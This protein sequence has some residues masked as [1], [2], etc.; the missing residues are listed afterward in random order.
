M[1][2]DTFDTDKQ[3]FIV[4]EV[5]NNH[6]GDFDVAKRLVHKAAECNVDAVKFQTFRTEHFVSRS[7]AARFKQLKS[8]ELEFSQFEQLSRLAHALGLLFIST[9]LDLTSASFLK[10]IVDCYKVASGDNNFFPLIRQIALTGKP[11]IISTGL[12]DYGQ[13]AQVVE[14]VKQQWTENDITGQLAI[15]H[16]VSSYPAPPDQANLRSTQFLAEKLD[17]VVGYS[18]HTIGIEASLLAIALGA[19]IIEK[20]FTLDKAYSDFRDHQLSADP[21]E[22]KELVRQIRQAE[23]MLGERHKIV[24]P[25]EE[26]IVGALRR[27][28]VA[29]KDMAQGHCITESDLTWLRSAG[30]LAPGEEHRLVG[31]VL[32]RSVCFGEQLLA[33]DVE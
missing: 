23:L 17:C 19:R 29:G 25:C 10:D 12:S 20:H 21:P 8:F 18:D 5:G 32:K 27:S 14:F 31:K 16:C 13:V 3:V 7:N 30:G 24:Q 15:L 22:M 28:I 6:E 9:P 4:A 11:M 33:S 26:A 1:I 2:I